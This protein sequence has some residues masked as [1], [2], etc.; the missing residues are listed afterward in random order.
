M[1]VTEKA[2]EFPYCILHI[3]CES[4]CNCADQT[5]IMQHTEHWIGSFMRYMLWWWKLV[6]TYG[7]D[8]VKIVDFVEARGLSKSTSDVF[9]VSYQ[10]SRFDFH[11][12]C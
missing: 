10:L 9:V 8:D 3:T 2:L 7:S 11:F 1:M 6:A 5:K 4:Q 12:S